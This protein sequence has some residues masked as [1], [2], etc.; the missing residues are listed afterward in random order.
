MVFA[1]LS[2]VQGNGHR[3]GPVH[4]GDQLIVGSLQQTDV[5]H[6]PHN[7]AIFRLSS[8]KQ[9]IHILTRSTETRLEYGPGS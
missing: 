2:P 6:S 4:G 7:A 5:V 8:K 1:L 3:D 9:S